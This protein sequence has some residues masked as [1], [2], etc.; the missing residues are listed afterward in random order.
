M[1]DFI[2]QQHDTDKVVDVSVEF[3][4]LADP[5]NNANDTTLDEFLLLDF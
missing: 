1:V 4:R 2:D 3:R 5:I